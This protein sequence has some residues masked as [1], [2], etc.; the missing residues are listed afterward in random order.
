M[1][2]PVWGELY[3][4]SLSFVRVG[5][6]QPLSSNRKSCGNLLCQFATRWLAVGRYQSI[7]DT[8][9]QLFVPQTSGVM[10]FRQPDSI[11]MRTTRIKEKEHENTNGANFARRPRQHRPEDRLLA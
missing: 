8:M 1:T 3:Q 7:D 2:P 5:S 4:R 11:G 9:V 6:L 10:I